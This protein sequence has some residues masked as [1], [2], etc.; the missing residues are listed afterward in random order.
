MSQVRR[1]QPQDGES[2]A[3]SPSVRIYTLLDTLV[4]VRID[5]SEVINRADGR[6]QIR[7]ARLRDVRK[8]LD[9]AIASTRDIVELVD[10]GPPRP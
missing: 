3:S 8:L 5:L 7:D 2:D 4:A 10:G 9:S 1:I 6:D